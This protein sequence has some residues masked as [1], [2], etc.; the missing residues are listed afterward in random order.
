MFAFG[1]V[2]SSKGESLT[3]RCFVWWCFLNVLFPGSVVAA[4]GEIGARS[5]IRRDIAFT[6][7]IWR[8]KQSSETVKYVVLLAVRGKDER[9]CNTRD[10]GILHKN[11]ASD[12]EAALGW[13]IFSAGLQ[14]IKSH[15]MLYDIVWM[16]GNITFVKM[17]QS[18]AYSEG[19]PMCSLI[20]KVQ[21][22][23]F[24]LRSKFTSGA[25][26]LSNYV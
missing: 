2:V 7:V 3:A 14:F 5:N 8:Q 16:Q 9:K 17:L 13:Y 25:C 24:L 20:L 12:T 22:C 1:W 15:F 11:K 19:S 26:S 10:R 21:S 23:V 18:Y 6:E 4:V